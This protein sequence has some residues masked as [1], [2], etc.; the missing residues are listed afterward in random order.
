MKKVL[1]TGLV[2]GI[3]MLIGNFLLNPVFNLLFPTLQAAYE[4]N[5]IFRPWED[6]IMIL[7]F[8]YPLLLGFPLAWIWNKTK[9]LFKKTTFI[10]GLTFGLIYF[11]TAGLPSFLIN[12]SSFTLPLTMIL[13]WSIMGSVNGFI[14]GLVLA[15]VNK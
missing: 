14:A 12:F 7:F 6:P 1:W 5:P 9:H 11:F 10:N 3:A 2:T 15:K 8:A 4:G 13:T